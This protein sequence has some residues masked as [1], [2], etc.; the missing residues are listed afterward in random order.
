MSKIDE[1]R[2]QVLKYK[3]NYE[4]EVTYS[5]DKNFIVRLKCL[6]E[7]RMKEAGYETTDEKF[8]SFIES[9]EAAEDYLFALKQLKEGSETPQLKEFVKQF[10]ETVYSKMEI[11]QHLKRLI[12]IIENDDLMFAGF[13]PLA[14]AKK[15]LE[16]NLEKLKIWEQ[17]H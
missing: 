2:S 8:K 1:T 7:I 13:P 17:S 6:L 11:C 14:E 16:P 10:G 3:S 4:P 12:E 15:A 5:S 9:L